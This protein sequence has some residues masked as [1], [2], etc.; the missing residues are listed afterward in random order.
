[1]SEQHRIEAPGIVISDFLLRLLEQW[2]GMVAVGIIFSLLFSGAAF[3][4]DLMEYKAA[5]NETAEEAEQKNTILYNNNVARTLTYYV[6]WQE[7]KDYYDSSLFMDSD[8][9]QND[10][11]DLVYYVN[12]EGTDTDA[13]AVMD[14]YETLMVDPELEAKVGEAIGVS[15]SGEIIGEL[16]WFN[17]LDSDNSGKMRNT[18]TFSITSIVPKDT[19]S[20][21]LRAAFEDYIKSAKDRIA[22]VTGKYDIQLVSATDYKTTNLTR[23]DRKNQKHDQLIETKSSF[24]KTFSRLSDEEKILVEFIAVYGK[25]LEW[26]KSLRSKKDADNLEE[27]L[28]QQIEEQIAKNGGNSEPTTEEA[29]KI[30]ELKEAVGEE[31]YLDYTMEQMQNDISQI[32]FGIEPAP[33]FPLPSV[34]KIIAGLLLGMMLYAGILF[35]HMVFRRTLRDKDDLE[36]MAGIRSFGSIYSYPYKGKLQTFLHDRKIYE[37]RTGGSG[38]ALADLK[39]VCVH[40]ARYAKLKGVSSISVMTMGKTSRW[41]EG[42]LKKQKEILEKDYSI[43]M[44]RVTFDNDDE[45]EEDSVPEFP[46]NVLLVV[47]SDVTT[48]KSA[49]NMLTELMQS[50]V[51]VFGSEL[52]EGLKQ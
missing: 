4:S 23:M 16:Y 44:N 2:R 15:A 37:L 34:K 52:L 32:L 19:D 43:T 30:A 11:L 41:A 29:I 14:L 26:A 25:P 35:C 3:V 33:S 10:R 20:A 9:F 22:K 51:P 48:V 18:S 42:I 7:Q 40:I 21:K 17:A 38:Q 49:K 12:A 46:E 50:D 1:M 8:R 6:N 47:L 28:Q 31:S 13:A 24:A 36:E 27:I 5:M 39:K 45:F